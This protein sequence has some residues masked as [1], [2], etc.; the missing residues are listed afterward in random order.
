MLLIYKKDFANQQPSGCIYLR[1][2]SRRVGKNRAD[3]IRTRDLLNPIQAHY[4]AVLQPVY[5][6][7]T[8]IL[9]KKTKLQAE[10]QAVWLFQVQVFE[11]DR[12]FFA[13]S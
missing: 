4:Q 3:V 8:K 2:I 9:A 5:L 11:Y 13:R 6:A 10:S 1:K 7:E 12:F